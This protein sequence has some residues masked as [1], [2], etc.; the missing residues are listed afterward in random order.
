MRPDPLHLGPARP[1]VEAWAGP[2]V[3]SGR[4]R[5][6]ANVGMQDLGDSLQRP[7]RRAGRPSLDTADVSLIDPAPLGQLSLGQTTPLT[8][9]RDLHSNVVRL[10]QHR[11]LHVGVGAEAGPTLLCGLLIRTR[12]LGTSFRQYGVFPISCQQSALRLSATLALSE[13][14]KQLP[15]LSDLSLLSLLL[16]V[17]A[18][19]IAAEQQHNLVAVEVH[20]D[21]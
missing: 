11:S 5:H 1:V 2:A 10:G 18:F 19:V 8:E 9:L 12:H 17:S 4:S 13:L 6:Q 21:T 20:E 15:C 3:P 7:S 14:R 16:R